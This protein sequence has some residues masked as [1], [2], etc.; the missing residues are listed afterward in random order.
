MPK[1]SIIGLSIICIIIVTIGLYSLI[2]SS[3]ISHAEY[4]AIHARINH[5]SRCT[6]NIDNV[7]KLKELVAQCMSDSII[8]RQES[9][10]IY[11][12]MDAQDY[13]EFKKELLR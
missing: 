7:N 1:T 13:Q 4:G 6:E 9:R 11:K 10:S 2:V 8:S 12:L 3:E 5:R